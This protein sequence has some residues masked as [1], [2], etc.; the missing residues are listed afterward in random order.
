[1]LSSSME[2]IVKSPPRIASALKGFPFVE[3]PPKVKEEEDFSL[4]AMP[5][6]QGSG[7]VLR[8]GWCEVSPTSAF[9]HAIV[10][11]LHDKLKY[12]L[13]NVHLDCMFCRQ[14]GTNTIPYLFYYEQSYYSMMMTTRRWFETSL[15]TA[16]VSLKMHKHHVRHLMYD[17]CPFPSGLPHR[18]HQLPRQIKK[19]FVVAWQGHHYGF[20]EIDVPNRYVLLKDGFLDTTNA[21][22]W[23]PHLVFMLYKWGLVTDP[24]KQ[25][26]VSSKIATAFTRRTPTTPEGIFEV[27]P[28]RTVV[29]RNVTE[30]GP[31]A[32][33]HAWELIHPESKPTVVDNFRKDV[34]Q[35]LMSMW[36]DFDPCLR[37]RVK[38]SKV[39]DPKLILRK[40][41]DG[42][43]H[44]TAQDL[45]LDDDD[46]DEDACIICNSKISPFDDFEVYPCHH[47]YHIHCINQYQRQCFD[48][49]GGIVG[50]LRCNV[51]I[52]NL[53]QFSVDRS[54]LSGENEFDFLQAEKKKLPKE[55]FKLKTKLSP[56]QEKQ[57]REKPVLV[58][59]TPARN[60]RIQSLAKSTVTRS[61][62]A[63]SKLPSAD[64]FEKKVQKRI[65]MNEVAKKRQA[66]QAGKMT[67]RYIEN[68]NEVFL[69]NYV[70]V[71][72][73]KRDRRVQVNRGILGVVTFVTN[74]KGV[75]VVTEKGYLSFHDKLA[76][77]PPDTYR[78]L[79]DYA[80]VSPGLQALRKQ[81]LNGIN[82]DLPLVS[83]PE[84]HLLE[85]ASWVHKKCHCR[86]KCGPS[87]GCVRSKV[88][89]NSGCGCRVHNFECDNCNNT[90]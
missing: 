87:C 49:M 58:M 57:T 18:I 81:V 56:I 82:P 25:V 60:T 7:V 16:F 83:K 77:M 86:S 35:E 33:Y 13:L 67:E 48:K 55:N 12:R 64:Y 70:C 10:D 46:D 53:S 50:C 6:Q 74:A 39:S 22:K 8:K 73:D 44:G 54:P 47:H 3:S 62:L 11:E 28:L 84:V 37:V 27:I 89:C 23:I 21:T 79:S 88:S 78:V 17:I 24:T 19:L 69:G 9:G 71:R 80:T 26:V 31:I 36:E 66:Q 1:M 75:Q 30:C 15:I 61:K 63:S 68:S 85:H 2:L 59:D 45:D 41:I 5:P 34:I 43:P 38:I 51:E 29:Q 76:V 40:N 90:V 32:A 20:I 14:S 42:I 65:E 52:T 72:V 4:F